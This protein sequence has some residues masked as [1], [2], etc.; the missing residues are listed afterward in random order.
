MGI[1]CVSFTSYVCVCTW[2]GSCCLNT[3][4]RSGRMSL[5]Y[6]SLV[7]SSAISS[8]LGRTNGTMSGFRNSEVRAG[9]IR[10]TTTLWGGEDETGHNGVR[11]SGC[12]HNH[13]Y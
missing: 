13:L 12:N 4:L 2:T 7:H 1:H 11:N 8:T 5:T 6:S 9:R 3:G 10:Y